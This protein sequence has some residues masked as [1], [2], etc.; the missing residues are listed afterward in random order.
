MIDSFVVF[1]FFAGVFDTK[2]LIVAKRLAAVPQKAGVS[3]E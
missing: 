2:P 3:S 1:S